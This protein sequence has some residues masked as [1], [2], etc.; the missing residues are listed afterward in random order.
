MI[1]YSRLIDLPSSE[2]VS[3][4]QAKNWCKIDTTDDDDLI[5]S[6]IT[7]ARRICEAYAGLSFVAQ[8]R[9]IKLDY[10]PEKEI[11]VPYGPVNSIDSF[12]YVDSDGDTQELVEDT[13]FKVADHNELCRLYAISD[14]SITTWPGT[15][16][17]PEC[18]TIDYTAGFDDVSG[19]PLPKQAY[20]AILKQVMHLYQTRDD[21]T[22][23]DRNVVSY[24]ASEIYFESKALLDD[25]RVSWNAHY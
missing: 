9:R 10:F 1:I 19:N 13:D 3:R 12:T 6:L 2:P 24:N 21:E 25:I 22:M 15:A 8:Q 14:N 4:T 11:I 17:L 20:T 7:T 18:V 23:K 16:N 5:D